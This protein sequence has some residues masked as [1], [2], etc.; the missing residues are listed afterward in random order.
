MPSYDPAGK[1][2][3]VTG[4]AS[5]I[6]RGICLALAKAGA[7]GVCALDVDEAGA[8]ATA[9]LVVSLGAR[10][11]ALRCDAGS[12]T[13]L[14][15]AV[16]RAEA[17]FGGGVSCFVCNGGVAGEEVGPG[18]VVA[19]NATWESCW[20][21]NVMQCVY[22]ARL[23]SVVGALCGVV[24]VGVSYASTVG[25]NYSDGARGGRYGR[26]F[27]CYSS[28]THTAEDRPCNAC[29]HAHD[30]GRLSLLL[31]IL[32]PHIYPTFGRSSLQCWSAGTV[33]AS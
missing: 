9:A 15:A 6:G 20:R 31:T 25:P 16:R 32:S 23:V 24:V 5:G 12:E 26:R 14:A 30:S 3:V 17:T 11:L 4:A 33:G 22:A 10:A 21:V 7:A 29:M 27:I 8:Q 1:I 19:G 2:A 13:D 18:A 28:A